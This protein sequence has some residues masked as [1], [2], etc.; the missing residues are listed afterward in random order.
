MSFNSENDNCLQHKDILIKLCRICGERAKRGNE[1]STP[2]RCS[3][4]HSEIFQV[5]RLNTNEDNETCHP[6]HMCFRCYTM[7]KKS[8]RT[9]NVKT[10]KNTT[11]RSVPDS[12]WTFHSETC[13]VCAH[14]NQQNSSGRPTKER[15]Q[16][17]RQEEEEK[18]DSLAF[19]P[20]VSST[21]KK[22]VALG[23]VTDA[24]TSPVKFPSPDCKSSRDTRPSAA[25]D[26][27][28]GNVRHVADSQTSPIKH[29][30]CDTISDILSKDK[31]EPLSKVEEK[32]ATSLL[33][34][35]QNSSSSNGVVSYK[36]G[37]QP[38]TYMRVPKSR[39][40]VS[41]SMSQKRS[42]AME[43]AR[44]TMTGTSTQM[45]IAQHKAEIKRLN[46]EIK[47]GLQESVFK[48]QKVVNK[49]VGLAIKSLGGLSVRQFRAQKR[50]L[51][52]ACSITFAGEEAERKE[53]KNV[54]PQTHVQCH[55]LF[56][57][58][59][60]AINGK[61]KKSTPVI[62]VTDL[63]KFVTETLDQ[64]ESQNLLSWH[65]NAIPEDTIWLKVG[66]DHGGGS[67]KLSVQIANVQSP[68]SKH[69][70]FMICMA[71]AKD[72]GFNVREILSTYRK[73]IDALNNLTW[74][75]KQIKLHVFG[76]YDFLCNIY[77]LSGANGTY[78]CLWCYANKTAI[79]K[80]H[81]SQPHTL[82]RQGKGLKRDYNA[83][84]REGSNNQKAAKHHN[85]VRSPVF[86]IE[87][88]HVCPPYLH[89]VLG[90]VKKHHSLLEQKCHKIDEHIATYL[91][92]QEEPG[93]DDGTHFGDHVQKLHNKT[94]STLRYRSGPTA[95]ALDRALS[96][97]NIDVQSFHGRSFTGNHCNRYLKNA[98]FS[99]ICRTV[100]NTSKDLVDSP[101]IL[102]EAHIIQQTFDELNLRF[103]N[104]HQQIAHD[105]PVPAALLPRIEKSVDLCMA[106]FR[107]NFPD[108]QITP[109]QHILEK[110][111]IEWIRTWG[112]GLSLMGEQGGEQLHATINAL[113]RR[114]WAIRRE[115][116]Q[117]EFIMNQ[118]HT[119]V[120][121]ALRQYMAVFTNSQHHKKAT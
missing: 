116:K 93:V 105:R 99:D 113:K 17:K 85:V 13:G 30:R 31:D 86:H 27:A 50:L 92:L 53:Q 114:A 74:K 89:I 32:L 95:Q 94:V 88:D 102:L 11:Q 29:W 47:Q 51:K 2:K 57:T 25:H 28:Q 109:K 71:N 8:L 77:G 15:W 104:V 69:N 4:Y 121:P 64:F 37:G 106:F 23:S 21:P 49:K 107:R 36:T 68:N 115:D 35:K 111:C 83:F 108:I 87:L 12:F 67:F 118:H 91:S 65:E 66:G 98:V 5:F 48:Q 82:H 38:L 22:Q 119:Q 33:R 34:R 81:K 101:E 55:N 59:E 44:T 52:K 112:F 62:Y 39:K 76:D 1:K 3:D 6:P 90:I 60:T 73:E 41:K 42:R 45:L 20:P 54:Q 100:V 40:P 75:G 110:H 84:K 103:S 43:R 18:N 16:K 80:S 26:D 72:S 58:C 120:S 78:P 7:M 24:A 9:Q 61:E 10:L 63:A 46:S 70:T 117:L 79:Q 56:F 19:D 97:H 96:K 14:F